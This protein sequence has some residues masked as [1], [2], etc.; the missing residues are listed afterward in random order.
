VPLLRFGAFELDKRTLELRKA[1]TPV[2]LQQQPAKVLALLASRAGELVT[3][4]EIRHEV[5]SADT[6]V[7]FDQGLNYC[8]RQIRGALGDQA[9]TPR[10]VE[11]LPRRG[12]RFV[13]TV[14][15]VPRNG[16]AT[17]S[18]G[19]PVVPEPQ[20]AGRRGAAWPAALSLLLAA[21]AA[22]A[23]LWSRPRATPG[24]STR[25]MLAV[26]PF[27]NL[28]GDPGREVAADGLTEEMITQLARLH[29]GQLGVI[30]R[31]SS[32]AYK[33]SHKGVGDIGRELGVDYVLE[34]SLRESGG[35]L[36]VAA[37]LIRARDGTNLWAE[38]YDRRTADAIAIQSELAARIAGA[39]EKRLLPE[40]P[41]AAAVPPKA[42]AYE[43]YRE[44]RRLMNQDDDDAVR[45]AREAFERATALDRTYAPAHAG[46]A[47]A[48]I[49][50]TD[51]GLAT[52]RDAFPAA[53]EAAAAALALDPQQAEA[54][55]AL[56]TVEMYYD[57]DWER[58]GRTF[59]KAVALGPNLVAAHQAY[60]GYF[61]ARGDQ[62]RALEEIRV[63]RSLDPLSAAVNVDLA[64][65]LYRARRY[66]EALEQARRALALDPRR[67]WPHLVAILSLE[68]L[69]RPEAVKDAAL[70]M[71]REVEPGSERIRLLSRVEPREAYR[72]FT[73]QRIAQLEALPQPP[74]EWLF[75]SYAG[76]GDAESAFRW[77]S[78]ALEER[79]RWLVGLLKVD[80]QLDGLRTD[81]RYQAALA[82]TRLD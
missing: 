36:R 19:A 11:T 7:D 50:L 37:Q 78:Q 40:A 54:R 49:A 6:F 58:A 9:E 2:K 64:W 46:L 8:V 14:D 43:A 76:L 57:W 81:R 68:E 62:G 16:V 3:R 74:A 20:P 60:A 63:A 18:A 32:M 31:S 79:S 26:L 77:L 66:D 38:T 45:G 5:W 70:A 15:Q 27:D 75:E 39:L 67:S 1:G 42:T 65:Y 47:L 10:F 24:S 71:L 17:P 44:G 82:R 61:S 23:L 72:T 22:V 59:D 80:P 12:Y 33:G 25:L 21:L 56:G 29:P 51:R 13:A 48:W 69:G 34:G 53:R 52:T 55:L 30:A 73:R 41:R 4:E 35:R 28:S